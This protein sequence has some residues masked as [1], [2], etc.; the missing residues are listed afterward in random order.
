MRKRL[1]GLAALIVLLPA[2]DFLGCMLLQYRMRA[3]YTGWV[4][5]ITKQGW[6]VR[7]DGVTKGGFPTGATLTI[8]GLDLSGGRAMLPGGLDWRADRVVLSLGLLDFWRLSVEPQGQQIVRVAGMRAITCSADSL[9]A[10][11]P[12]GRGRA[13]SITLDADGLT[14]SV[15]DPKDRPDFHVEHLA[16]RLMARLRGAARI[17]AS[18]DFDAM[19]VELPDEG[20]WP[21]GALVKHASADIS[22]A[23][24]ALSGVAASDQARAW[25]DWGGVLTV[26]N[27]VVLWGPLDVQ[28][29]ARMGLDDALQP[30]G[31]GHAV[32]KGWAQTVDAL[33]AG[34][35]MPEGMAQTV[36]IVMGLMAKGPDGGLNVPFKVKDSTLSVGK[37]P[38]VKL[39]TVDWGTV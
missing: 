11:V 14:A 38:L 5:T 12:L 9:V 16:L 18:A 22:L 39:H 19:G 7:T 23:S 33:A 3:A 10:S 26:Q 28:A 31:E 8:T 2:A 13:D 30:A 36:K 4:D 17:D 29:Q 34:G 21:L 25:H 24:P 37:I 35:V 32:I 27:L 6:A 15:I 20:R 1:I